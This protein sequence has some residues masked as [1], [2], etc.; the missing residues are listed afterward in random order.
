M[1]EELNEKIARIGVAKNNIKTSL[2]NKGLT[3]SDNIEDYA[4]LIDSIQ[5]G[6]GGS[7]D[8]N[9]SL[10]PSIEAM[11]KDTNK[12]IGHIGIV[13]NNDKA[14]LRPNVNFKRIY[15]P[16]SFTLTEEIP[17]NTYDYYTI[18][19][20]DGY[21]NDGDSINIQR[22]MICLGDGYEYNKARWVS[23]DGK[24]F[25]W[26]CSYMDY[27]TWEEVE[28]PYTTGYYEFKTTVTAYYDEN[29]QE[30]M[31][32]LGEIF[33][34]D[35]YNFTGIYT[36]NSQASYDSIE[37]YKINSYTFDEMTYNL[38]ISTTN[39][40]INTA[41]LLSKLVGDFFGN[42]VT[43]S[44]ILVIEEKEGN[45]AKKVSWTTGYS[46][47]YI[48]VNNNQYLTSSCGEG[49]GTTATTKKYTL[50]LE[51]GE[52]TV[53]DITATI[54]S[55]TRWGDPYY[56]RN[57]GDVTGKELLS[58]KLEPTKIT[59]RGLSI[60]HWSEDIGNYVSTSLSPSYEIKTKY[61]PAPHQLNLI[62]KN[63]LTTGVV[64]YGATEV[65]SGDGSYLNSI[66]S[67]EFMNKFFP[68]A[69]P[70][71]TS[72]SYLYRPATKY[73]QYTVSQGIYPTLTEYF[74]EYDNNFDNTKAYC[75]QSFQHNLKTFTETD[76]KAIWAWCNAGSSASTRTYR[77]NNKDYYLVMGAVDTSYFWDNETTGIF[78]ILFNVTDLT[79]EA[80]AYK[81]GAFSSSTTQYEKLNC[82][83]DF[84]NNK[85]IWYF[86][87][88][89]NSSTSI[90]IKKYT[91]SKGATTGSLSNY[92]T[93][94][95]VS[96]FVISSL[97]PEIDG[98]CWIKTNNDDFMDTTSA[99]LFRVT[100]SG[101]VSTKYTAPE[102]H[103]FDYQVYTYNG[104]DHL[105]I[106]ERDKAATE[107][108][109][110]WKYINTGETVGQDLD[111]FEHC[112]NMIAFRV[113]DGEYKYVRY[114]DLSTSEKTIT[115]V[116]QS[117]VARLGSPQTLR[118]HEDPVDEI[119]WSI[120]ND[121]GDD[122]SSGK[123]YD[124]KGELKTRAFDYM[125]YPIHDDKYTRSRRPTVW[126]KS[127]YNFDTKEYENCQ[128]YIYDNTYHPVIF[129]EYDAT[130]PADCIKIIT[131]TGTNYLN[132]G[133]MLSRV[134]L[135]VA[136]D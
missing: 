10:Y 5:Q 39:A 91:M 71:T 59:T 68:T 37:S 28:V 53:E 120:K 69:S 132:A 13:Y 110:N 124:L 90:T 64:A 102:N 111:Y 67:E 36:Y 19:G 17:E 129:R 46:N 75:Y 38:T 65:I 45:I 2:T 76:N 32:I 51:T 107:A 100:S 84:S 79:I 41:D 83:Y 16:E 33:K 78:G 113:R 88:Y 62:N 34:I 72:Y 92:C 95:G 119:L 4:T 106:G 133:S 58:V 104:V 54:I 81:P 134:Y 112:D 63:Q 108:I 70:G 66:P 118:I 6:T 9:I 35:E 105:F 94:S 82:T 87:P 114:I 14:D 77:Y 89:S 26:S 101:S 24:T 11:Q 1:Y 8:S 60:Y 74:D 126:Y 49:A 18:S 3:P 25:T 96:G 22:D 43:K 125:P 48:D 30:W 7:D 93:V 85:F 109:Y 23:E 47:I 116:E 42:G 44:G 99:K 27:D 29:Y 127:T 73:P 98:S 52:T 136:D 131:S 57:A 121:L 130:K 103:L 20:S 50:D 80:S 135:P 21:V 61:F 56:F 97:R 117:R 123:W 55:I 122:H 128:A 31:P 115:T 86:G 15:F 12:E 40:Y